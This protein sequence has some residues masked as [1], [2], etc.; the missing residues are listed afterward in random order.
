MSFDPNNY[1][2]YILS[3]N[4]GKPVVQASLDH[5]GN[6]LMIQGRAS[7]GTFKPFA[8]AFK[9]VPTIIPDDDDNNDENND[10][11]VTVDNSPYYPN[12][13]PF[14]D[15]PNLHKPNAHIDDPITKWDEVLFLGWH[16]KLGQVPFCNIRYAAKLGTLLPQLAKCNN[17]GCPACHNDKQKRR[18]W[19]VKGNQESHHNIKNAIYPGECISANQLIS[20]RP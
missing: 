5:D 16:I 9:R 8:V 10:E 19:R 3:W 6:L 17:I 11:D 1:G 20:G 18:S 4:Q 12:I 14:T 13:I 15:K 7:Y 2:G